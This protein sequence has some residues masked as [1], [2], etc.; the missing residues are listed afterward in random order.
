ME[1]TTA[2]NGGELMGIN[3]N[4]GDKVSYMTVVIGD[5][6]DFCRPLTATTATPRF[7]AR[8]TR[9]VIRTTVLASPRRPTLAKR[10]LS[11]L[12]RFE[13]NLVG[14]LSDEW[15]YGL[16]FD[17]IRNVFS[18]HMSIEGILQQLQLLLIPCT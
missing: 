15:G 10:L 17:A 14:Y 1:G 5:L 13:W 11:L 2:V 6:T 4:Y 8:D 16:W 9:V 12:R 7:N 18:V 3:L